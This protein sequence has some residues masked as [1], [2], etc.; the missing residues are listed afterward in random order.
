ME[1]TV[2]VIL[3]FMETEITVVHVIVLVVDVQAPV[4]INVFHV[5]IFPILYQMDIAQEILH[6]KLEHIQVLKE[7]VNLVFRIVENVIQVI[8]AEY[9]LLASK[10]CNRHLDLKYFLFVKQFAVM[11]EKIILKNVMMVTEEIMMAV[12]AIA[13]SR[14][15]GFAIMAVLYQVV[16]V[17]KIFLQNLKLY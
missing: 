7:F 14:M 5:L 4:L 12:I 1:Q 15:V 16:D 11:E 2:S 8:D 6:V 3:D 9:V 17:L 13:L 10:L